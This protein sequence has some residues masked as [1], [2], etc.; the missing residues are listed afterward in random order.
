M[1]KYEEMFDY[2]KEILSEYDLHGGAAK[3]KINYSRFDHIKRVYRW[4]LELYEALEDKQEIDIDALRIATIFHDCGY[5][6]IEEEPH[7]QTGARICREYLEERG[8]EQKRI[9]FICNLVAQHSDKKLLQT[10]IPMEL[11]LLMEADLLDDTGAQ[12]VVMDVWMEAKEE[13]ATLDSI[14]DHIKRYSVCLA[15]K[16]PMRT[17]KGKEIW[18]EKRRIVTEFFEA[19]CYDLEAEA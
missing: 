6:N 19:Y 8:Y 4:M 14:R 3:N 12:G 9:E 5:G 17:K 11:V 10:D 7:A 16:N 15:E 18:T 1:G 2:V 13:N